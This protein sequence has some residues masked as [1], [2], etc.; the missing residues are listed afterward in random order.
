MK[1]RW[2]LLNYIIRQ[3]YFENYLEIGSQSGYN[4]D[5]IVVENKVSVDPNEQIADFQLTSDEFFA[6]NKQKFG[7]IFID[8]LHEADQVTKDIEN[9]LKHIEEGGIIVCNNLIPLNEIAQRVPRETDLWNGDVWRSWVHCRRTRYD[10]T[11]FVV[12]LDNGCGIIMRGSQKI[13]EFP[14]G[15]KLSYEGLVDNM[16]HWLNL[17]SE[18]KA[19]KF[20]HRNNF[21]WIEKKIPEVQ[22]EEAK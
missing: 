8:G 16:H 19:W 3:H 1:K 11:M 10:L 20:L 14:K 6:Q 12:Q 4:F 21:P 9:A 5:Q 22:E 13:I 18:E 15:F 2:D 17:Y 7:L